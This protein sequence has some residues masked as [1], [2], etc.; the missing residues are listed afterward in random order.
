MSARIAIVSVKPLRMFVVR[1]QV[2][3]LKSWS[4]IMDEAALQMRYV[5]DCRQFVMS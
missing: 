5:Q 4:T 3:S 1:V 2:E